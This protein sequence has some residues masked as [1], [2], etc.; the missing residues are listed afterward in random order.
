MAR[1]AR[2]VV[3]GR[4]VV[5]KYAYFEDVQSEHRSLQGVVGDTEYEMLLC[6][7]VG[8]RWTS[9]VADV[10]GLES[11]NGRHVTMML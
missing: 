8:S 1:L 2:Q 5:R 4:R 11:S 7:A 10:V 6:G 9:G 3:Q